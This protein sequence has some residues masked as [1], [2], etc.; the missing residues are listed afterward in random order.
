MKQEPVPS[1]SRRMNCLVSISALLIL[2]CVCIGGAAAADQWT[3]VT[4][5]DD[6]GSVSV[7][8][9]EPQRIVSLAPSNTEILFSLGL[10]SKVVGVTEYCNYPAEAQTKSLVGGMST[11][12]VERVVALDP[13]I[14][15]GNMMNGEDNVNHLRQ[16]GY[17]VIC[18]NPDSVEGTF[19][20]IRRVGTATGT[21]AEAGT[22]IDSMQ[23][24]IDN[25][26][27]KIKGMETYRP[28]VVH[29]LSTD[30][31]WV[32]G[33]STFQDTLI[34]LAGGK[35][36]FADVEGWGVVT[37]ERMIT[38]DPDIILVSSGSGM[39]EDGEDLL[40]RT[41]VTDPRLSK[42]SAVQQERVS[43]MNG[44]TFNRGGPRIVDALED[45][46]AVL[47]PD[48]FHATPTATATPKAS[49]FAFPLLLIGVILG[50]VMFGKKI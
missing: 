7:I 17:T 10:G 15:F 32:S 9:S 21:S 39:G 4:I 5:T 41:L 45:L 2:L 1:Q 11:V 28:T 19:S 43:V 40:K 46:A 20:A 44:D 37:L 33:N 49:G 23:R 13:D 36:A 14:I 42:L 26:M 38:T 47:Y 16:L 30:P 34:T 12:N 24:R 18:L 25:V 29:L 50:L 8:S 22:L 27:E 6:F 35:N 3:P 48:L 31:Y